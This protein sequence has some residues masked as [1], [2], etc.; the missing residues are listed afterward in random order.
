MARPLAINGM[1]KPLD[2]AP[3][4]RARETGPVL[5]FHYRFLLW[6]VSAVEH[7]PCR[8][9]LPL[10]PPAA[11]A[12]ILPVIGLSI[13]YP[14]NRLM[15]LPRAW[16][17]MGGLLLLL[18]APAHSVAQESA[19]TK[20]VA[21]D[22]SAMK[23]FYTQEQARKESKQAAQAQAAEQQAAE[24]AAQAEAQAAAKTREKMSR[25]R[26]LEL[27][28]R[29]KLTLELAENAERRAEQLAAEAD[30]AASSATTTSMIGAGAGLLGALYAA[31]NEVAV[32]DLETLR[33][34]IE[35]SHRK[36]EVA[37]EKAAA[38]RRAAEAARAEA[39]AAEN[40]LQELEQGLA[41]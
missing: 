36:A 9:K 22:F 13:S 24:Q 40:Y 34:E 2:K 8:Q 41:E 21:P 28:A 27:R 25:V 6:L 32:S 3:P 5:E 33:D 16:P 38:A 7:F 17:V 29:A 1:D 26:A 4:G 20:P 11:G 31:N 35:K 39:L 10:T 23:D 37:R 15:K 18:A 30:R 14:E 12:F 19:F